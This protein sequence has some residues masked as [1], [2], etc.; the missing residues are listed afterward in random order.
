MLRVYASQWNWACTAFEH[1]ETKTEEVVFSR[2]SLLSFIVG[3]RSELVRLYHRPPASPSGAIFILLVRWS[4]C[5]TKREKVQRMRMRSLIFKIKH[6]R[7]QKVV[8]FFFPVCNVWKQFH[9]NTV[10]SDKFCIHI[11]LITWR[12]APSTVEKSDT[13]WKFWLASCS[14]WSSKA[15]NLCP[16]FLCITLVTKHVKHVHSYP[17][18]AHFR[19][20]VTQKIDCKSKLILESLGKI[21]IRSVHSTKFWNFSVCLAT[22]R[23]VWLQE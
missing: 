2:R 20:L 13:K 7:T 4:K 17:H 18:L 21:R 23:P 6:L 14:G 15:D 8:F 3:V 9:N 22:H 12:E 16:S 10:G 1:V 11:M 19:W 5:T